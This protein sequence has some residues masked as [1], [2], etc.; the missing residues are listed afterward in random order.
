MNPPNE[1]AFIHRQLG[2]MNATLKSMASAMQR[3]RDESKDH[4]EKMS[5]K[6][7]HVERRVEDMDDRLIALERIS[8][9]NATK[10]NE[11]VMPTVRKINIWEQR[12]IGFLAFAGF[13]GTGLGA[14]MVKY[15]DDIRAAISAIFR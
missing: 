13:A 2:E 11:E 6:L 3:D 1:S 12:G 9:V 7:D 4:R 5:A 8:T 14:A 10:L 15:G